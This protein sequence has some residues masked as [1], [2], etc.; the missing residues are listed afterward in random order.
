MTLVLITR[1]TIFVY[2]HNGSLI[3]GETTPSTFQKKGGFEIRMKIVLE[4]VSQDFFFLLSIFH[5]CVFYCHSKFGPIYLNPKPPCWHLNPNISVCSLDEGVYNLRFELGVDNITSETKW[6]G[7]TWLC[8]H[9]IW[10][11]TL[12]YV[13]VGLFISIPVVITVKPDRLNLWYRPSMI[14]SSIISVLFSLPLVITWRLTKLVVRRERMKRGSGGWRNL[15]WSDT[16]I[17]RRYLQFLWCCVFYFHSKN[18]WILYQ[19]G[20]F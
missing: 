1:Y 19:C 13:H 12:S 8:C 17:Y 3:P 5:F 4:F 16:M 18:P 9:S 10:F 14:G 20:Q 6:N 7:T 11:S 2:H 15:N